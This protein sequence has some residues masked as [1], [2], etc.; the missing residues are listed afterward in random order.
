MENPFL[1]PQELAREP[2]LT[3][4][5][6]QKAVLYVVASIMW[7]MMAVTLAVTVPIFWSMFADLEVQLPLL[8]RVL[9]H[10]MATVFFFVVAAAVIAS[11]VVANTTAQRQKTGRI[12]F[13]LGII[14]FAVCFIGLAL[15][16]LQLIEQLS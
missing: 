15:P 3:A 13:V 7:A 11:G 12:A 14:A 9:L 2:T 1:P 16:M 4:R 8:T 5:T 6:K 10:P